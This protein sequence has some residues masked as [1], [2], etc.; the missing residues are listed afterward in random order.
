MIF[1]TR[2]RPHRATRALRE[3]AAGFEVAD[4]G[5]LRA[6][7]IYLAMAAALVGDAAGCEQHLQAAH[8]ANPGFE[9]L[10]AVDLARAGAWLRAARGEISAAADAAQRAADEAASRNAWA[11]EVGALH[12]VARFGRAHDVVDRLEA[13]TEVVDGPPVTIAS[14]HARALVNRD[15]PALDAASRSFASLELDLFAAEASAAAARIHGV[16][17]KRSSAFAARERTRDL[18]AR[19]ESA[20]SPALARGDQP[21]VLTA[22]EREIADLARA[23]LPS[24][25]IAQRLGITTRT[26][27]NLLGRVYSKLGVSGRKELT[28]TLGPR[29]TT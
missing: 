3:A 21:E 10:F 15:G 24:R 14:A 9:A 8:D 11:L 6:T 4:R 25:E 23:D 17:G 20:Q 19:C 16:A 26:V 2:G 28:E 13:L 27:D 18:V 29:P 12:D 5:F 22:R 1:V 7:R